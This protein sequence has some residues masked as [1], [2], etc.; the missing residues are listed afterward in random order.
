M[1]KNPFNISFGEKPANVIQRQN[2]M[3]EIISIF[4]DGKTNTKALAITGPRGSGK[5]VLLSMVKNYFDALSDW[6]CVDLNPFMDIHEQL[7]SKLYDKGKIKKLFLKTEFDISFHGLT[8]KISGENPV[9]NINILLENIFEY[10]KKKNIKVLITIDDVASN[11]NI[12]AFIYTFHSFLREGYQSYLM[13][14]GLYE[15]VSKLE[16]TNNLA[17]LLR[18]PKIQLEK[19]NLRAVSMS[20]ENIFNISMREAT[21]LAKETLGYAYAYQLL[22]SIL[23]ESGSKEL[24]KEVLDKYDIRLEEDVYM[25]I[26]ESLTGKEKKLIYA[27]LK[28]NN[29]HEIMELAEM[30]NSSLQ[31]YKKRLYQQGIVDISERGKINF[32]LPRFKEFAEF[33]K[34]MES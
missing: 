6:I 33:Q 10:L 11:D 16:N 34:E 32:L 3:D 7:A 15:N 27:I 21:N 17:F 4:R 18:T 28:T 24:S 2:E 12:K 8:F 25:K 30:N 14:T 5:T 9:K 23:Y 26:W 31:V 22:G 1:N 19:L 13:M 29:I 20:Y